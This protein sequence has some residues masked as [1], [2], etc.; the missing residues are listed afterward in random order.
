MWRAQPYPMVA[1]KSTARRYQ[2]LRKHAYSIGKEE[3]S[4][5]VSPVASQPVSWAVRIQ[6]QSSN[7]PTGVRLMIRQTEGYA[8]H[9]IVMLD[10][11]GYG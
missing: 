5:S 2:K 4:S 6:S 11:L 3:R 10:F 1:T 8:S 9:R 7:F